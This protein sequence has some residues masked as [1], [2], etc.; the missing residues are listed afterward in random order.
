MQLLLYLFFTSLRRRNIQCK[1]YKNCVDFYCLS[2]Y[3]KDSREMQR[4]QILWE[5]QCLFWPARA[6]LIIYAADSL[7][8]FHV[9]S[10][11]PLNKRASILQLY[12]FHCLSFS[13]FSRSF[14]RRRPVYAVTYVHL[15]YL[16]PQTSFCTFSHLRFPFFLIPFVRSFLSLKYF[17]FIPSLRALLSSPLTF[18]F[19]ALQ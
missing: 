3:S 7:L 13:I 11:H 17:S 5:L 1:K 18:F 4:E 9:S 16:F 15:F 8:T 14:E 6:K 19:C 2:P 10:L 12:L